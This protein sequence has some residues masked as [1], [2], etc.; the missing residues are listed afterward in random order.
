MKARLIV[1]IALTLGIVLALFF[2][3][4]RSHRLAA[5]PAL[6]TAMTNPAVTLKWIPGNFEGY[7]G[8]T[9]W[10]TN[11]TSNEL[12]LTIFAIE[13]NTP[14]GWVTASRE[15]TILYF[16]NSGHLKPHSAAFATVQL[17]EQPT[18]G[19]WRVRAGVGAKLTGVADK[20]ARVKRYPML[21]ERRFRGDT[22][23]PMN[24]FSS[25]F[26]LL[27][28]LPDVVSQEISNE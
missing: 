9:F 22:N 12:V 14:Q 24:P 8:T 1:A 21:A 15:L 27:G 6:I 2:L 10:A 4:L 18:E 11:H 26:S 19:K 3:V 16:R 5:A 20:V 25:S 13:T 23:I 17:P 7:Y 28:P